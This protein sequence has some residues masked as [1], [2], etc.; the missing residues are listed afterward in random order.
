MD[1]FGLSRVCH[2]NYPFKEVNDTNDFEARFLGGTI[3]WEWKVGY[4]PSYSQ[5]KLVS[6]GFHTKL[7]KPD[8][9]GFEYV[10]FT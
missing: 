9:K 7:L 5:E 2:E 8:G 6:H 10:G 4:K 3:E 1:V